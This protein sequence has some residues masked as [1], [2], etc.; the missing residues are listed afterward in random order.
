MNAGLPNS[1]VNPCR[2]GTSSF[3]FCFPAAPI[4]QKQTSKQAEKRLS[5]VKLIMPCEWQALGS[6]SFDLSNLKVIF[7]QS[8]KLSLVAHPNKKAKNDPQCSFSV[9]V[10][11]SF[12][13]TDDR[14]Q[15]SGLPY[16]QRLRNFGGLAQCSPMKR[17][18]SLRAGKRIPKESVG[19]GRHIR[20]HSKM[21]IT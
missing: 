9:T 8:R 5:S 20:T 3:H 17:H 4:A 10:P 12:L 7:S 18:S 19:G 15:M 13:L 1:T 6:E 16:T 14:G 2:K 11:H 21:S